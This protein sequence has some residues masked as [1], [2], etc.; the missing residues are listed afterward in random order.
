MN[1]N[2]ILNAKLTTKVRKKYLNRYN[3]P[4]SK[5]T[6][7]RHAINRVIRLIKTGDFDKTSYDHQMKLSVAVRHGYVDRRTLTILKED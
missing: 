2:N 6:R 7:E 3:N 4:P 5:E 1:I